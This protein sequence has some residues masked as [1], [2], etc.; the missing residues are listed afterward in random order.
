MLWIHVHLSL[1]PVTPPYDGAWFSKLLKI[2]YLVERYD[3]L[4]ASFW[5]ILLAIKKNLKSQTPDKYL[6]K[7]L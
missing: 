6:K 7:I 3:I 1:P 5:A 2:D 4:F